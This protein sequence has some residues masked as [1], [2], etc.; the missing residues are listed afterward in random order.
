MIAGLLDLEIESFLCNGQPM[1][2][3]GMRK[4]NP[5]DEKEEKLSVH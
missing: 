1:Q 5:C 2:N 4:V 3:L